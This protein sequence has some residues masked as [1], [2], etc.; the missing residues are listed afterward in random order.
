MDSAVPLQLVILIL[1]IL[2]SAFFSSAE[3]A[4]TTVN[5][6]RVQTLIEQENKTAKTLS[7]VIEDSGK[8]LSTILIGNNIVNMSASSLTTVMVTNLF[9]STAV[10]IGTGVITLLILIFG[11]ITPKTLAATHAEPIALAYARIIYG[12]MKIMTPIIFVV[13]N[14][15]NGVLILVGTA[16]SAFSMGVFVLP[17][18]ML[19]PGVTGLGRLAEIWFSADV[20][21]VV[22]ACN[23]LL[24]LLSLVLLGWRFA[25]TIVLGSICFPLFLGVFQSIDALQNLVE[26]PL[27]AALCAG[28]IEGVGL[29]LI[30][31]AGGSSGGSDV[32]PIILNRKFHLPIAP[33]LYGIDLFIIALQLPYAQLEALVL[34]AIY[35]TLYTVVMNR[36]ILLGRGNVQFEIFSEHYEAITRRILELDRGATLLH[37][38]SGLLR[39]ECEMVLAVVPI[40][41]MNE[42]KRA[43][44]SIDPSAF[45]TVSSVRD[46]SGRGFTLS[47]D[48]LPLD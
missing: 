7:K 31:R 2:L 13:S 48:R 12:L 42:V 43:V 44:I 18:G 30:I 37:G 35:A 4:L 10:G 17:Y 6:L 36:T 23:I 47:D 25:A 1:L 28:A 22:G 21:L 11:E 39:R 40:R 46:V 8:L 45:I 34:S 29:G 5:K 3:T 9:G 16:L 20:T 33:V 19:V 26:D 14:L 24:L 38:R 32:V 15:A 41:C 27:Y